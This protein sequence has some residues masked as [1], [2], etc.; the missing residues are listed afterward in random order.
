MFRIMIYGA[1][2]IYAT[3]FVLFFGMHL[4]FLQMVTPELALLRSLAWPVFWATGWPHGTPLP[5]D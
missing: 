1:I 3:G 2:G 4:I 5:M